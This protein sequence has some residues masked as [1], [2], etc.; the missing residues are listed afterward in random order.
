MN[1]LCPELR[2]NLGNNTPSTYKCLLLL[3]FT[4]LLCS[5]SSLRDIAI[6]TSIAPEFPIAD[7]VQ[8]LALLNRS[9]NA[10]FSN[11]TIDSLERLLIRKN[12][13]LDSVY[14]D[15]LAADTL[16]RVA[17]QTLF[18]S[19]RFDVIIP[20][21]YAVYR[22]DFNDVDKP[23][24]PNVVNEICE[25]YKVDALLVLEGFAERLVTR[26]TFSSFEVSLSDPYTATSDLS[27]KS[28]WRLYRKSQIK[29]PLRFSVND[30]IFW[31]QSSSALNDLY[32]RMPKTKEILISGGVDAGLKMANL[33]SPN[34]STSKRHYYLTG[35]GEIDKVESHVK[36]NKWDKAEAIWIKF[37]TNS[38]KKIRAKME[39]NLALAAE[40]KGDLDGALEWALK[41][42]QSVYSP[43]IDEYYKLLTNLKRKRNSEPKEHY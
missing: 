4:V 41:S 1:S 6:D 25:T 26:Y 11:L 37:S 27:H 24:S 43:K 38:S 20:Q 28:D 32:L 5:C 33:I 30:S 39:Y 14:R 36:E 42:Y 19:G 13:N 29:A 8:S 10:Q 22:Y 21:E 17:A 3:V 7:D 34:W 9:M 31:K 23:L 35:N 2:Y 18:D 12:L 15:S 16:L 40:M